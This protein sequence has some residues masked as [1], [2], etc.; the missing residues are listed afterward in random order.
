MTL[1]KFRRFLYSLSKHLG[2]FSA[3]TAM[4]KDFS[5]K[6]LGFIILSTLVIS[7]C[8]QDAAI[9]EMSDPNSAWGKA[10]LACDAAKNFGEAYGTPDKPGPCWRSVITSSRSANTQVYHITTIKNKHA[11]L[12]YVSG[13]LVSVTEEH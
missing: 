11:I 7:G 9:R 4:R 6:R 1:N 10:W 2:D 3:G 13:D 5:T 8:S 12:T